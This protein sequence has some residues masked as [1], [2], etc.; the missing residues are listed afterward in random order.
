[1]T[2]GP[3]EPRHTP[4]YWARPDPAVANSAGSSGGGALPFPR[5]DWATQG[6]SRMRALIGCLWG[7]AGAGRGG[8]RQI[9]ERV[10]C[11]DHVELARG[12][13]LRWCR[14]Q[15]GAGCFWLCFFPRGSEKRDR[16][17]A[18]RLAGA[19]GKGPGSAAPGQD[20]CGWVDRTSKARCRCRRPPSLWNSRFQCSASPRASILPALPCPGA[21]CSPFCRRGRGGSKRGP[22]E[23]HAVP[24]HLRPPWGG[25]GRAWPPHPSPRPRRQALPCGV[26]GPG[27]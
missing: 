5:P 13:Q 27:P 6:L 22:D 11:V 25:G 26:H 15:P 1:M 7:G 19:W 20:P 8:A 10:L 14:Q 23:A 9:W 4:L 18:E 2:P 3:G 21:P 17:S 24:L 12:S 16:V